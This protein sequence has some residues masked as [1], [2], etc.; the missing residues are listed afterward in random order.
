MIND[1][2]LRWPVLLLEVILKSVFVIEK[3]LDSMWFR[4]LKEVYDNGRENKITYGSFA[5]ASRL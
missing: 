4:L 3:N 1:R 2:S 5:G